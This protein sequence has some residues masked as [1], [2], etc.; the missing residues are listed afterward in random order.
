MRTLDHSSLERIFSGYASFVMKREIDELLIV[1]PHPINSPAAKAF[2]RDTPGISHLSFNEFQESVMSF[3]EYLTTFTYNHESKGLEEYFISPILSDV[4]FAEEFVAK[5]MD[6][7]ESGPIAI[8]ASYGMGK[9]SL[10]QH[11]CYQLATQFLGGEP[12]R[13]P[14]FISLGSIAREQS[15]EGLVSAL[16]VGSVPFVTSYTFPLF[17]H[18]NSIGRFLIIL[19]GFDEMKHMMTWSEFQST[20]GELNRLVTGQ[21]KVLLLG[22]PTAFLSE[23]ERL[24]ALR[25]VRKMGNMTL[26]LPAAPSYVEVSLSPFSPEQTQA[27]IQRYLQFHQ[28]RGNIDNDPEFIA[29]RRREI[30]SQKDKE[31]IS[32]PVHAMMLADVAT[33]PNVDIIKMSRFTLYNDFIDHLIRR[34]LKKP[35]RGK[36]FKENDR[37][38][39]ACDLAWYLW[40][41]PNRTGIGWRLEDLPDS[42]FEPYRPEGDELYSVKRELL[43]ASSCIPSFRPGRRFV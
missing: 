27:F 26:K 6:T 39:F 8:I 35:G 12:C 32:R 2:L 11:I 22:R 15:L 38:S 9:T 16:L 28:S 5:W 4:E 36:I 7:S 29:R 25:G 42:L 23:D 43:S 19:D 41:Q 33:D 21:A 1:S 18:L 13:V 37:R 30:E 34:E 40:T 17:M 10:G 20:F 31:L 3:R 24:Y 14:I